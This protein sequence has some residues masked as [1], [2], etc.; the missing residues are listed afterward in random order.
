M[1]SE[2]ERQALRREMEESTYRTEHR[3]GRRWL[4]RL[5]GPEMDD[6]FGD[7]CQIATT[8]AYGYGDT[9]EEA[10]VNARQ[11]FDRKAAQAK[12]SPLQQSLRLSERSSSPV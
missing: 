8:D 10:Y 5:P 6:R 7:E 2:E 12:A 4:V 9:E 3:K 1:M 11:M